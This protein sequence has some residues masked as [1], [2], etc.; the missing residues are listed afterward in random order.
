MKVHASRDEKTL[1]IQPFHFGRTANVR[2]RQT[3][4]MAP[5]DDSPNPF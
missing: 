1:H 4:S 5:R 2:G 3:A